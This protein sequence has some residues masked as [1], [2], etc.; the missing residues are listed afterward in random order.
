MRSGFSL[1]APV[2][3]CAAA[4]CL[5]PAAMAATIAVPDS[6][7]DFEAQRRSD[8][9]V[10]VASENFATGS[11]VG[12]QSS[13]NGGGNNPPGGITSLYFFQLPAL[14]A[15]ESISGAT[16]SVGRLPDSAATAVT[17]T[18]NADL[19]AVGVVNSI[20]KTAADAEKFFYLGNT[21]QSSLPAG[22]P[23]VGGAVMRLMDNFLVP[24]EF[25]ASG[26]TAAATPDTA[27]ITSYVQSLYANQA[28]NGFTPGS[29]FL[30][31]RLNPDAD[32]LP[33]TGTQRYTTAF[34]G[35]AANGGAGTP[36][37]RPLVTLEVVPEPSSAAL[38]AVGAL[39]LL[40]R[41]R[42]RA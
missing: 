27:D 31:L 14:G 17:P 2:L 4:L 11:R 8:T 24:A 26:G 15:G 22:G 9:G 23:T 10:Y 30:V 38:V 36:E 42:V 21:A 6:V 39:A 32:V 16:F 5:A 37:N 20:S 33:T 18:F 19:Y 3:A 28:A 25:I 40:R 29:S 12:F 7:D 41:R 1:R 34:Q 13:F 35:T